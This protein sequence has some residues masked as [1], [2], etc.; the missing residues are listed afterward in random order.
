MRPLFFLEES[1]FAA[2]DVPSTD[3]LAA[4]VSLARRNCC[5]DQKTLIC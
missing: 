5:T 2:P 3:P 4:R 1:A